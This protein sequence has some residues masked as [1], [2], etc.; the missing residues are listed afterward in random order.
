MPGFGLIAH[1]GWV[2]VYAIALHFILTALP[3]AAGALLAARA[4]ARSLAV[5]LA[6]GLATGGVAALLA[7]WAYYCD[8]VVGTT[9]SWALLLVAVLVVVRAFIAERPAVR[10]LAAPLGLWGAASTFVLGLGF[11]H[12]GTSEPFATAARRFSH[13]L[14]SDNEIPGFFAEWYYRHGHQTPPVFGADWLSSDR[15]PLQVGYVLSQRQFFS[16]AEELHYQVLGTVLQQQWV[17]GLYALLIAA[18]VSRLTR[19]GVLVAVLLSDVALVNGFFVWP[20]LLPAAMM[21]AIAALVLTPQ[22]ESVRRRTAGAVLVAALA[23]LAMMGHGSSVFALAGIGLVVAF[24]GMPRLRWLAV[25]AVAGAV[26]VLPWSAYQKWADP[27]G[28][29]LVKWQLA[30]QVAIDERSAGETLIDEY[31]EVGWAGALE[32]KWSNVSIMLGPTEFPGAVQRHASLE[33]LIGSRRSD[34]FFHLVP[35]LG[36]L[37]LGPVAMAVTRRRM[38]DSDRRFALIALAVSAGAAVAAGLLLFGPPNALALIHV[39]SLLAPLLAA[40]GCVAAL[41]AAGRYVAVG[42]LA[43]YS[44]IQLAVYV[45]V[46]KPEEGSLLS[47]KALLLAAAAL[48]AYLWLAVRDRRTYVATKPA[49]HSEGQGEDG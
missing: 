34:A 11:A 38:D 4:G 49:E 39:S 27:P 5:R 31:R 42:W 29:R 46:L 10:C 7:F 41:T 19:A 40:A 23:G 13:P 12:G 1:S 21:L 24:R 47:W 33:T 3:V 9:F 36:L 48:G 26:L 44:A 6:A 15:P 20:K 45:P 8:P 22:W 14:P 28:D 32:R 30:G 16:G 17:L 37:L 43:L 2:L 18:G 25:A 35:S